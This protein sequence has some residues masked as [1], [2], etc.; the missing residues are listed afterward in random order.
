MFETFSRASPC[1]VQLLSRLLIYPLL[2]PPG[3]REW[4]STRGEI[5]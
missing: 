3:K 5:Y 2:C 4:D 1:G